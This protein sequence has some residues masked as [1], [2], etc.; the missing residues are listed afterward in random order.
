MK[1]LTLAV[2][3][4]LSFAVNAADN[5]GHIQLVHRDTVGDDVK[6]PNRTGANITFGKQIE[7]NFN[8]DFNVQHR[9]ENGDFGNNSAR[10]EIGA[11]PHNEVFYIRGALGS[12]IDVT[13]YNQNH[14]YFSIEPGLRWTLAPKLTA[15]TGYRYRDAFNDRPDRTHT[16]RIGLEYAMSDSQALTAGYDRSFG[17]IEFT[18]L[19][20]GYAI[21]Y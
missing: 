6:D 15:K 3:I 7:K 14:L 13:S 1:K 11:T 2:L 8:M 4:I 16:A 10:L 19:S 18:G 12:A 17:D 21:K 9:Q 20:L 5:F